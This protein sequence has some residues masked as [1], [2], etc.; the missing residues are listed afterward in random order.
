MTLLEIMTRSWLSVDMDR[1]CAV[2][3]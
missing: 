3:P 1:D 2:V